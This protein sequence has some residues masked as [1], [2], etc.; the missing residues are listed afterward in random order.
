MVWTF[1]RNDLWPEGFEGGTVDLA[2]DTLSFVYHSSLAPALQDYS[3]PPPVYLADGA[4]FWATVVFVYR[5]LGPY[6][7]YVTP[8]LAVQTVTLNFLGGV[9]AYGNLQ[10]SHGMPIALPPNSRFEVA[11]PVDTLQAT[12]DSEGQVPGDVTQPIRAVCELWYGSTS[13]RYE[14]PNFQILQ[15]VDENAYCIP[16]ESPPD[17]SWLVFRSYPPPVIAAR[18]LGATERQ[19]RAGGWVDVTFTY[20]SAAP[21]NFQPSFRLTL[22]S[23][24]DVKY[25]EWV[26]PPAINPN[27]DRSLFLSCQAGNWDTG[28]LAKVSIDAKLDG[29]EATPWVH[30]D[31]YLEMFKPDLSWIK[32]LS[33]EVS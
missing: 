30:W 26:Q 20:T 17:T 33:H 2:F 3:M 14:Y 25:G 5:N 10:F 4:K 32:L 19:V 7:E 28:S 1:R 27:E 29:A 18:E 31:N 23:G 12:F 21:F 9:I 11:I 8:L 16:A 22:K 6:T 15:L 13:P 24:T